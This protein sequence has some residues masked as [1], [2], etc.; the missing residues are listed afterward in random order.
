[1]QQPFRRP[2]IA[3]NSGMKIKA[4]STDCGI[5]GTIKKP[6]SRQVSNVIYQFE[7]K[8]G[9]HVYKSYGWWYYQIKIPNIKS[10]PKV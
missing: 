8:V 1:M 5:E 2:A 7:V 6:S 9:K 10:K 3:F 4:E